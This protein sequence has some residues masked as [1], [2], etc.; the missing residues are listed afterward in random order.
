[1]GCRTDSAPYRLVAPPRK[2][3]ACSESQLRSVRGLSA[4]WT[5]WDA[6][7]G[8]N[9]SAD[10]KDDSRR[11]RSDVHRDSSQRLERDGTRRGIIAQFEYVHL[12]PAAGL[13]RRDKLEVSQSGAELAR[14]KRS[15]ITKTRPRETEGNCRVGNDNN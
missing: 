14:E 2:S 10:A 12:G 5:Y 1:M 7:C 8:R 6:R 15:S 9:S 4:Y 11:F 3:C 13:S